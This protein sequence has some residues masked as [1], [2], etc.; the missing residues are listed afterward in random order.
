MAE[1]WTISVKKV[2]VEREV[3]KQKA[4][5]SSGG[6]AAAWVRRSNQRDTTAEVVAASTDRFWRECG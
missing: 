4:T 6:L 3:F 5:S 1:G 2:V